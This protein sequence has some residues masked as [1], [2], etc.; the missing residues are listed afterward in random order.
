[1]KLFFLHANETSMESNLLKIIR[2]HHCINFKIAQLLY[3]AKKS[4][5]Q[6]IDNH[7]AL[8]KLYYTAKTL[9]NKSDTKCFKQKNYGECQTNVLVSGIPSF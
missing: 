7:K 4:I 8:K 9:R 6:N 2:Y 1:L 3:K 5:L